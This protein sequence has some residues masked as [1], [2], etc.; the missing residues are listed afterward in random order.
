VSRDDRGPDA[1]RGT[2][3]ALLLRGLDPVEAAN[4]TGHLH[5]LPSA[6]IRWTVD[7][8]EAIVRRRAAHVRVSALDRDPD[9]PARD[10]DFG[11]LAIASPIPWNR[12]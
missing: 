5:G 2:Y 7:E 3:R 9:A 8:V 4:V 11:Q 6:G 1:I 12:S 10:S